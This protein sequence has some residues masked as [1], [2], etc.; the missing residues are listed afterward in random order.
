MAPFSDLTHTRAG[1]DSSGEA[2]D[3]L[4]FATLFRGVANLRHAIIER[5][6]E[7]RNR[8]QMARELSTY[9]DRELSELGFSRG[10]LPMIAAGT[11]RR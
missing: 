8:Q 11:Y 6:A 7:R 1:L 9:T 5:G 2:F 4:G 10:D 3:F